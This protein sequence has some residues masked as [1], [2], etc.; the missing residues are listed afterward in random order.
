MI[1]L[2]E[3]QFIISIKMTHENIMFYKFQ[4]LLLVEY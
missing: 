4:F 2:T 3:Y 1:K